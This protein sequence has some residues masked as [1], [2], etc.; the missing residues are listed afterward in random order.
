VDKEKV[1]KFRKW[2]GPGVPMWAQHSDR[3]RLGGCVLRCACWSDLCC[4]Q[5]MCIRPGWTPKFRTAKFDLKKLQTLFYGVI[6]REILNRIG[7]TH[8]CDGRTEIQ[9]HRHMDRHCDSKRH[10]SLRCATKN[11]SQQ[12]LTK[13]FMATAD[14]NVCNIGLISY[15]SRTESKW[16]SAEK[17]EF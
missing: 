13:Y 10:A 8:A 7:V 17:I 9:T 11:Y 15:G 2:S 4:R 16:F 5:P 14:N 1:I 12:K 3:I 6:Q